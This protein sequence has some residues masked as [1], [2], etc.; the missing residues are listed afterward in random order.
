MLNTHNTSYTHPRPPNHTAH[1]HPPPLPLNQRR[2]VAWTQEVDSVCLDTRTTP[3]QK[4][5]ILTSI[6]IRRL[7]A[8]G[9][10]ALTPQGECE[11]LG[12]LWYLTFMNRVHARAVSAASC[13]HTGRG[14]TVVCSWRE[15]RRSTPARG[16]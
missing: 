1:T 15:I 16:P 14:G 5:H 12:P 7:T 11:A 9:R 13:S 4:G 2:S 3:A 6:V 10:Q 8:L